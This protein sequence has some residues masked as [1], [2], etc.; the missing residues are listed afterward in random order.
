MKTPRFIPLAVA[1]FFVVLSGAHAA[2]HITEFMA[3][4]KNS[5][6]DSDGEASDWI[7]FFNSGPDS[8]DLDGY[9]LTDEVA[10]PTKWRFPAVVLDAGG[11]LVVF[12]S[13]KNRMDPGAELHTNFKLS[14]TGEYVGLVDPDGISILAEFGAAGDPLPAQFEDVSYGLM[15]TGDETPG[16]LVAG[17]SS[18]KARVPTDD[19]LGA[20]WM[21]IGFDDSGWEA[22]A[23]GIGYDEGA[24]YGAEFGVGGD[25][26]D[27]FND[28]NTSVYLRIPFE[29]AK[30]MTA[31]ELVLKMKYDD[32]FAA[33]LNGVRVTDSNA[34]EVLLW[35]SSASANHP[36]GEATS[37]QDFDITSHTGLLTAG[38]NTLAIQ[39]LNDALTSSDML[40]SAELHIVRVTDPTIGGPGY[41]GAPSP[42]RLNGDTFGG[43]VADTA[44]SID[45]GF[46]D[47]SFDLDITTPTVGAEIRYTLDGTPPGPTVGQVYT[48]PITISGTT[49]VRA[50]AHAPGLKPTNID[51][52]T[53]VFPEDVIT[54]P[55]MRAVITQSPTY[56]P[57]MLDSLKSVPTISLVTSNT[58]FENETL[59]NIRVEHPTSVEMIFPDGTPG[60]QENGGLSNYGGR[61]TNFRKKSFRVAFRSEFGVTKLRYPIFDGYDYKHF[62]PADTFDVINLR[63]GSHDML[64]RGA[65][66]SNRF[67]DDSML[68]M[69]N[70]APHGR[71]VHLYL[72]GDYWGQYHLR[73]RW[74]ADM[75][76]SYYG[77]PES[78][79]EAVNANDNFQNDEEVY[80]GSGVFWNETKSLVAGADPFNTAAGHIDVANII[81]FM[82]L[83]V[84]GDSESEFRS[85]GSDTMGV[86][87]KFMI[88]DADGYLRATSAGKASHAG[89]LSVM[90]RMLTGPGGVDFAILLA[91]R[92][93]THFFNDGALTAAKN[94]ERL[95]KR[96]DEASL[97]FLSEAARWGDV[98]REPVAWESYQSNLVNNHFPALTQ[99]MIDRFRSAGM[100]PDIVAPIF[101]QY[102][103]SVSV[104]T[105]L[106]MATDADTIYYTLDGSDP[107]MPGGAPNP[108]AEIATFGGGGGGQS[109]VTYMTTGQVWKFLDDGSDQGSTWTETGFDD[110]AWQSGPSELGYGSD[111]EGSGTMVGFGP[112]SGNKFPTTYFRTTVDIPDPSVF[113][114][115]LLRLKY[116]DGIAVYIDGVEI[117]RQ[118]L[119]VGAV[120]SDFANGG[121]ADES[122]FK[123]VTLPTTDLAVGTNT[124]AVEVHQTSGGSSDIRLDMILRGQTDPGGG[125]N[126][127][128]PFFLAQ[129]AILKARAFD[130]ASGEWSAL[131]QASFTIDTVPADSTNLVVSELH[132]HPANPATP[133]E[134]IA[135]SDRDDF[136]FAELLGV[137]ADAIDLSG[138]RFSQGINF[139]FPEQTVVAPGA[140]LLLVR[141]SA[142]FEARYGAPEP[143]VQVFE[144]TG[145]LSNDGEL[146]Q[147]NSDSPQPVRSF[148][149]NDQ[150][151]WPITA[152]GGG[153]SLVLV[154]PDTIPDHG[155][156]ANWTASR[157]SG[158]SPGTAEPTGG[159]TYAEWAALHG[160]PGG[161][162]DDDDGDGISQF[163][164]F[165]FGSRPDL[166]TDAPSLDASVQS[167]DVGGTVDDY[168]TLTFQKNNEIEGATLSVEVSADLATWMVGPGLTEIIATIDNGDGTS[169][170]TVR[171]AEPVSIQNA[172]PVYLRLRGS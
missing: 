20:T 14:S 132:Y 118:N 42:G 74:S 147:I 17:G 134:I 126:V 128:D 124:F 110:S 99:T 26:G 117:A 146:L 142:A 93:H 145:R 156:A 43:F 38:T 46:F 3:D 162:D 32:G 113:V 31:S 152:D 100:Y 107:R 109:P 79:Y 85:F 138:V 72:N 30:E 54:Q 22:V 122:G 28:V 143:G 167:I 95:Q 27:T 154:D 39:G 158:G 119:G 23:M 165:L 103:G 130:S 59:G 73:E 84:S 87:F 47:A 101:S 98:F 69:G 127:T 65:Y 104:D 34:P 29:Y 45:R 155:D 125:D 153:P 94:I 61:F 129:P 81:D 9:Y 68:D 97:G 168:V 123:D 172:G 160:V 164:E 151:P 91:D 114:N 18:G 57:Q 111:G 80:D 149:Y 33:F 161:P 82:L 75:A 90:N 171:L 21:E 44:F 70:I 77:G 139:A 55:K 137:G 52:H 67:T 24:T 1:L 144:Y 2:L 136:E 83:W 116:D 159:T 89:P 71:F 106:T 16:V 141:D 8:V 148:T 15:Q 66:M 50:L 36:D 86:P 62:P 48:G 170:V 11:F 105:A 121:V 5:L 13:E 166:S 41:L 64:A 115:F 78:D 135:S 49:V 76:K 92:I 131:N 37:L 63:S 112:D 60:F 12:A 4:N 140:R 96:V 102:G 51:T 6:N 40:I 25:L 163:F 35:N 150:V 169:M 108:A 58:A 157:R 53:Y 56:G 88:K 10:L 19:S 7:E 133:E 120:F